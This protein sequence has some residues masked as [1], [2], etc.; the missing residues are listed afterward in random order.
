MGWRAPQRTQTSA[1]GTGICGPNW[2]RI[3]RPSTRMPWLTRPSTVSP[4]STLL[5]SHPAFLEHDPGEHHP[6]CPD[7]LRAVMAALEDESFALLERVAAPP[8]TFEQLLRVHPERYVETI[9]SIRPAA[10]EIVMIDGDTAMSAGSAEAAL[11]AAGAV[12]AG[13]DAVLGA[14][15]IDTAFAAVRPPGHHAT[16]D[17]P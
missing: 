3:T 4:M 6:E 17:M 10:D 5:I 2:R 14:G 13:V 16:P 8:A 7:R 1:L 12:V 9:L 15:S 11:H